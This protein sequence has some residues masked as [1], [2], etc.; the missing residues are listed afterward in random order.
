MY[1]TRGKNLWL[2]KVIGI[3]SLRSSYKRT[4]AAVSSLRRVFPYTRLSPSCVH[5]HL[6]VV[7][8]HHLWV[9]R[10]EV[11]LRV[12]SG[13]TPWRTE[14][15][16]T[17]T[18]RVRSSTRTVHRSAIDCCSIRSHLQCWELPSNRGRG[19]NRRRTISSIWLLQKEDTTE[20]VIMYP[21]AWKWRTSWVDNQC[22]RRI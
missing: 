10:D 7:A 2:I 5:R 18:V 8:D 17:R 11:L 13:R 9:W 22:Y 1:W 3:R 15:A 14:E 4:C 19:V 20:H 16:G 21:R 12:Y 6:D